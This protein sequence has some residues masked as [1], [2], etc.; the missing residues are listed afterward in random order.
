MRKQ[1]VRGDKLTRP[2]GIGLPG[3]LLSWIEGEARQEGIPK[4]RFVA[5]VLEAER[6]RRKSV[7]PDGKSDLIDQERDI[8]KR[9]AL[10]LAFVLLG[11]LSFTGV[12]DAQK[13]LQWTTK[14][15]S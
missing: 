6:K 2:A 14:S 4:S 10:F 15:K 3:D 5:Q 8:Q 1:Y 12:N 9:A 7:A 11:R 13:P